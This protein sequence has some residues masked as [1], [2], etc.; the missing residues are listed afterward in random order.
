MAY[1]STNNLYSHIRHHAATYEV[2]KNLQG[3]V[4]VHS[5]RN[6]LQDFYNGFAWVMG[7]L[8]AWG[9]IGFAAYAITNAMLQ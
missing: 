3:Q 2:Q 4:V 7:N 6:T 9:A 8:I 5:E 1:N